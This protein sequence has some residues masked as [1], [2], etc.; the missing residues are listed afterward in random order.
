MRRAG[1]LFWFGSAL[2]L[3]GAALVALHSYDLLG[4]KSAQKQAKHWLNAEVVNRPVPQTEAEHA[5]ARPVVHRG[6]VVGELRIDRLH[7]SVMVFEGDDRD[8]L[9][10]GAGHIPGTAFS[11]DNGNIGI[12]AHRDTFFR[13]LRLIRANDVITLRTLSGTA[14]FAVTGTEIVRPSRVSVLERAPGRDLTLVTCYPFAYIGRAP[15]RFIVHA[16]KLS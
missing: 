12:A 1:F 6:E 8:V 4:A 11:P 3:G 16:R 13:P 2:I 9:K 5:G 10:I 7:M 15:Q 14:R